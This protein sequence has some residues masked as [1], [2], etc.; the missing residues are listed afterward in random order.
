[1]SGCPLT[2]KEPAFGA[3]A[4]VAGIFPRRRLRGTSRRT[5]SN[6]VVR[7]R[8][9]SVLQAIGAGSLLGG[10]ALASRYAPA[11]DTVAALAPKRRTAKGAVA[12]ARL[13]ATRWGWAWLPR[14]Q[15]RTD[16]GDII[17][18]TELSPSAVLRLAKEA[19]ARVLARNLA[20]RECTG[21]QTSA[22]RIAFEPVRALCKS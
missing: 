20:T 9:K 6:T 15:L 8:T 13:E 3:S 1:M 11:W 5:G 19:T 14:L 22:T 10:V 18:L 4:N 21:E 17:T 7:A 16:L 2:S 12:I